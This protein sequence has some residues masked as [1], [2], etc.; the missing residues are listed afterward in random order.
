MGVAPLEHEGHVFGLLNARML[1]D[2]LD[3]RVGSIAA[4]QPLGALETPPLVFVADYWSAEQA[5]SYLREQGAEHA[6]VRGASGEY[7]GLVSTAQLLSAVCG[8]IRPPTIGGMATP[9]GVYLTTGTVRGGVGDLA[10]ISTGVFMGLLALVATLVINFAVRDAWWDTAMLWAGRL[11]LAEMLTRDFNRVLELLMMVIFGTIFRFT[12]IAGTHAAEHQVVHCIEAGED[13]RPD[14][15]RSKPR[16]HPR[17]GTNLVAGVLIL[18]TVGPF[19]YNQLGFQLDT[20]TLFALIFTM[21]FWRRLGSVLQQYVTTRPASPKQIDDGI[22]AGKQLM[23]RH[24]AS[25][26]HQPKR[27]RRVWNMGI[28]Q[29]FIGFLI[30]S[31]AGMLINLFA[32]L[33]FGA[34][35]PGLRELQLW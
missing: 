34:P 8:R 32:V 10:L 9:F 13:L 12:W 16:V 33:V 21:I 15:V 27:W 5:L 6:A 3:G 24:Q 26:G 31:A 25:L 22:R 1:A 19:L 28:A 2:R 30:V 14:L 17:C 4:D 7:L 35:V 18:T 20:A 23:E 11:G 29:V